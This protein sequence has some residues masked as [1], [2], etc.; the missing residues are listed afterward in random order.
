MPEPALDDVTDPEN[1][2]AE[3]DVKIVD[4]SY[5]VDVVDE[6]IIVL[7][8]DM[9]FDNTGD[10]VE[11]DEVTSTRGIAAVEDVAS[12]EMVAEA[13]ADVKPCD[14]D[15]VEVGPVASTDV[16]PDDLGVVG[17]VATVIADL[18]IVASIYVVLVNV[19]LVT[20]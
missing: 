17:I 12:V 1:E 3:V 11:V 6:C 14:V 9:V 10:V 8:D 7:G 20:V 18:R 5:E 16:A 13:L 4:V 2:T 15:G 19:G